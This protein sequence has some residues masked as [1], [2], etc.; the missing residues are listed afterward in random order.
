MN[1]GFEDCTRYFT[2]CLKKAKEKWNGLMTKFSD[3]RFK[4]GHAIADLALYNYIEMRDKTASPSFLT[5]KKIE[6]KFSKMYP[7]KWE[8]MYSQVTF[9]H[10]PYSEALSNGNRQ[11]AI[12][13]EIMET[14]N[15]TGLW[16]DQAIMD[17]LLEFINKQH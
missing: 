14:P 16:D 1:A 8:P 11:R 5:R 9:S 7:G 12:M 10:V 6:N 3:M 13:D 4:D 17:R 15:I 2:K